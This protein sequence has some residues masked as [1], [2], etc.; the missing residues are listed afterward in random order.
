MDPYW[1]WLMSLCTGLKSSIVRC[2]VLTE[3]VGIGSQD[4]HMIYERSHLQGGKNSMCSH[5]ITGCHLAA[6]VIWRRRINRAR[7]CGIAFAGV[8][9]AY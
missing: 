6:Q 4:F 2:Q 3:G 8:S 7:Y 5:N 1:L 9:S